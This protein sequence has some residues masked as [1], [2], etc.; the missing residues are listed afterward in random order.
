MSTNESPILSSLEF[1]VGLRSNTDTVRESAARAN[2]SRGRYDH[3]S[4][5]EIAALQHTAND[6][7]RDA[8]DLIKTPFKQPDQS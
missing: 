8:D 5:N 2:S 3:L 6:H 7:K 4:T 1:I